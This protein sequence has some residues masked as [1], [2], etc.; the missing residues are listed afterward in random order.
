MSNK[1]IDNIPEYTVGEICNSIKVILE[2]N[3]PIIKIRGE[4]S[5]FTIHQNGH[6]YFTLK[7]KLSTIKAIC[8][9]SQISSLDCKPEIGIEVIVTGKI[10]SYATYS[11]YQII[12]SNV[13]IAGEGAYLKMIEKR[14]K[15]LEA[16]GLFS[17]ETKK[18]LPYL[19]EC[20]GIITSETGAVLQDM[21]VKI[22]ERFPLLV[23]FISVTVQGKTAPSEIVNAIRFFNCKDLRKKGYQRPDVIIVARGGGSREDLAAFDEE[24]VVRAAKASHIPLISAIGH[25]PDVTLLDLAADVR[26]ATPTAAIVECLPEKKE[27]LFTINKYKEELIKT[28]KRIVTF[29]E[30]RLQDIRLPRIEE[31]FNNVTN[32]YNLNLKRLN[33]AKLNFF[34]KKELEM[35]SKGKRLNSLDYKRVLNRGFAVIRNKSD[36]TIISRGSR[37]N[38]NSLINIE[39]YDNKMSAKITKN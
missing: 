5:S 13:E 27:L 23:S 17:L 37:L 12:I 36:D 32:S 25:E 15:A 29:E 7:D 16:E 3:F 35:D 30:Q 28:I 4:I 31:R 14:K 1:F 8:W 6:M 2:S 9:S 26:V 21:R 20:I 39:F 11:Q 10:S 18:S 34:E 19:P 24:D 38:E 22:E 33:S